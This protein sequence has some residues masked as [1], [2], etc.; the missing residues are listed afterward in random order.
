M[1]PKQGRTKEPPWVRRE[2]SGTAWSR[3]SRPSRE[4]RSISRCSRS[5]CRE[6]L[7]GLRVRE[8]ALDHE[9]DLFVMELEGP[10]GARKRICWTRMV[11]FDAERIPTLTGIR[12]PRCARKIVDF[13]QAHAA[14][15]EI[16]V[17]FRHLE[18]GWIDT[19]EPR[20]EGGG[21]RRRRGGRGGARGGE[22]GQERR[23]GA[24]TRQARRRAPVGGPETSI[25]TAARGPRPAARGP[26][27]EAPAPR[28]EPG[29]QRGGAAP[30]SPAS[31][32]AGGR[33]P[34]P[35]AARRG[36][37]AAHRE[38]GGQAPPPF[39]RRRRGGR[40][41]GGG[42][43]RE[44]PVG[45]LR[46][47]RSAAAMNFEPTEDQKRIRDA[48]R[49]F[50]ERRDR[51]RT[52]REW[53]K[54]GALSARDPRGPRR[55]GRH[56]HDG[57]R[58]VRRRRRRRAFLRPRH[59]GARARLRVD[60]GDR[61]GQQLRRVLSDLE[62]RQRAPEDHDPPGA[63]V[64]QGARGLRADRAAVGL[65]RRQPEDAG[66]PGRDAAT[67][68]TAPRPGSRTPARRSGTS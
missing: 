51:A 47:R 14:R 58:G 3:W 4:A 53:E 50:A 59:R 57:P 8:H 23:P 6:A 20:R 62:V 56:G 2:C 31:Q 25:G 27:R 5:I 42:G 37:R 32:R 63:R 60:G 26:R 33:P 10:D 17:T 29:P 11:L 35:R 9:R 41:P 48:V 21:R 61:L 52:W 24:P 1:S 16:V 65:G 49:E 54:T 22:R 7:P 18:E 43:D 46:R 44:V 64:R 34:C 30:P 13:L 66:R 28:R 19:P 39:R 12:R 15:P 36:R 38:S 68:S 45:R 55:D 40:G 67:S